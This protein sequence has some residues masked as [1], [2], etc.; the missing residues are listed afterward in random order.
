LW[1]EHIVENAGGR[2]IS[3]YYTIG[4]HDIVTIVEAPSDEAMVSVLLATGKLGNAR[5]E[6]LKAFSLSDAAKIIDKLP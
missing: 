3:E 6:I 2:L 5:N 1:Y 4:K